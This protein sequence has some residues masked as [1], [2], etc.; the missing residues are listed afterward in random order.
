MHILRRD[1]LPENLTAEMRAAG[2]R[3]AVA[4]QARQTM[5]ETRWLLDL[6]DG[7]EA[8]RGV[9]G[10]AP[11]SST[12]EFA[13]AMEE[14]AGRTKLKGLRHIVQGEPDDFLL[15]E[16]F[17][18]GIRAMGGSGLV[19]DLLVYERQLP[20]AMEFVD[21]HPEQE[22]VLDHIA[23]PLIRE[24]VME[25][26]ASLIRDFAKRQ[27]VWC[28]VSGMVTEADWATWTA[29]SLQPYLDVVAEAFGPRRLMVGSDWPVCLVACGY[30]QWF[31]VLDEYFSG[32]SKSEREAVFGLTTKQVYRLE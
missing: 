1:F 26:W 27:N 31:D 29:K 7:C 3:G 28:K 18:R 30:R 13:V 6:A 14:L 21:R 32:F 11:I 24:G 23:K 16:D 25:P 2:V 10:W 17:N 5:E 20:Q 12:K 15:R 4:V 19:Y 9:V 22:F 8:I